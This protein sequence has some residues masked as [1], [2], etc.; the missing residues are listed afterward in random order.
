M[1][2]RRQHHARLSHPGTQNHH[3]LSPSPPPLLWSPCRGLLLLFF[4]PLSPPTFTRQ[5]D[6]ELSWTSLTPQSS[7]SPFL[8]LLSFSFLPWP[9]IHHSVAIP[10]SSFSRGARR[11][12]DKERDILARDDLHRTRS[13]K[14]RF[15]FLFLPQSFLA[16]GCRFPHLRRSASAPLSIRLIHGPCDSLLP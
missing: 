4:L 14:E 16:Y 10:P 12:E 7:F 11:E 1:P 9:K 5:P 13:Y 2:P 15:V 6:P 3:F 8:L